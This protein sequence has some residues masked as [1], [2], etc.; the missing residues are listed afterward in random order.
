MQ[1][2]KGAERRRPRVL[3]VDDAEGVRT[4]L[5]TLLEL[6]GFE[7]DTAEDGG[8]ALAL[9]QGGAAPDVILLD[10]MMPGMEGLE[11]LR[12]I[13]DLDEA[14]PVV[15]L[16]VVGRAATIVEAMQLGA[17]DYLN[18]PFEEE[19]LE[20]AL[21][22]VLEER[23]LLDE[24]DRLLDEV[25][26][27]VVW[28]SPAMQH[29]RELID[30]VAA[31]D[32]TVLI[33]GESGVGKEIAA[34]AVHQASPRRERPFLKVNCA[35]LP[36]ELLESELFGYEAGAFTG[37]RGRKPGKFEL[38]DTG[39]IFLDEVGEMSPALQ[40]KLLQVLQDSEYTRLGGNREVRVDVRVLCATN[41]PL[42]QMV[43]QGTFREDLFFRL[44]VVD[45][46]LPPL[47]ERREEIPVLVD[48]FLRRYSARY[49]KPLPHLSKRLLAALDRHAF[50]GNVREL[51]NMMKRIV[52]LESE[53]PILEELLGGD[54][55]GEASSLERLLAEIEDTAGELPLREV[56]R[57]AAL[58]AERSAIERVLFQTAWNRKQAARA[59]GV[60]Y[61]TLLQK[62]RECG[63]EPE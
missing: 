40:A 5:A 10:L 19:E 14:V 1:A 16:S 46:R 56:G 53:K 4:Y 20:L 52:V 26:G 57:R 55:R 17:A 28:H 22:K 37:A 7:V 32:V 21:R 30:Q 63:L 61:K 29:I 15:V 27:S 58:A 45:L 47:R 31:T 11:T 8:R 60:S 12:R 34:R 18:K 6:R 38:A 35:A 36:E 2:R 33:Q 49:R 59:L 13:R 24:R 48:T 3:V 50:P 43:R 51:E 62:I 39:T 42:E 25:H 54:R 44:D 41:R 9:L 23:E